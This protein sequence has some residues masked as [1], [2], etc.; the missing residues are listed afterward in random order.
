MEYDATASY[1]V[2]PLCKNVF[3]S[4]LTERGLRLGII[5]RSARVDLT[6]YRIESTLPHRSPSTTSPRSMS[7]P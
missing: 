1:S 4:K 2:Y 5:L 7:K 6:L 3:E